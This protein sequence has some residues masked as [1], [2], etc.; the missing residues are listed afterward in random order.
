MRDLDL[1][2]V[3]DDPIEAVEIIVAASSAPGAGT[4]SD[5]TDGM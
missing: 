4:P 1:V 2:H 5:S 3:T